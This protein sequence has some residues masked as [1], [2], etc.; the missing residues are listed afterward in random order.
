MM[1][2]IGILFNCMR[3][4][5]LVHSTVVL[6]RPLFPFPPLTP[7]PLTP[8]NPLLLGAC[9]IPGNEGRNAG[10]NIAGSDIPNIGIPVALV[11]H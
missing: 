5:S 3:V 7:T 11:L 8:P 10:A 2:Y 6:A 4:V 9:D 1:N